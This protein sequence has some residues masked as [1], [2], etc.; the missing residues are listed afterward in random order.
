MI[1][2]FARALQEKMAGY[3]EEM[4]FHFK[5]LL[6]MDTVRG[7]PCDGVP[8]GPGPR[9]ALEYVLA[10]SEGFGLKTV[11]LDNYIGYSE[12]GPGEDYVCS[13]AHLDVVPPGDG[14][15]HPPFGAEEENGILYARGAGDDKPGVVVGLYTLRCMKELGY[16]PRRKLRVIYG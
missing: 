13:I 12:Y 10:L 9:R 2:P 7:E 3:R 6:K 14:W 5:E 1:D 8:F 11:N 4:L 15:T 16:V